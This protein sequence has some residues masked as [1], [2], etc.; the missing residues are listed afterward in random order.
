MLGN[1]N[2]WASKWIGKLYGKCSGGLQIYEGGQRWMCCPEFTS[3]WQVLVSEC[4]QPDSSSYC[5]SLQNSYHSISL[6]CFSNYI[7]SITKTNEDK[8]RFVTF[9]CIIEGESLTTFNQFLSWS[10]MWKR[11]CHC[12]LAMSPTKS[13]VAQVCQGAHCRH[14]PLIYCQLSVDEVKQLLFH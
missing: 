4:W 8:K 14:I 10:R 7:L 3:I 5:N 12:S 2:L 9:S 11:L 6:L 13:R 1:R